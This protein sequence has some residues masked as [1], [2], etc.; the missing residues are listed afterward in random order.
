MTVVAGQPGCSQQ[1]SSVS[2]RPPQET[3]SSC[4][5]MKENVDDREIRAGERNLKKMEN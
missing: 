3:T 2:R 1:S 5:C 4:N